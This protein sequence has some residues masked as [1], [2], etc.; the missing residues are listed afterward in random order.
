MAYAAGD[1]RWINAW[2]EC[3]R[4]IGAFLTAARRAGVRARRSIGIDVPVNE[5]VR[6][7]PFTVTRKSIPTTVRVWRQ[8]ATLNAGAAVTNTHNNS[9]SKRLFM[10]RCCSTQGYRCWLCCKASTAEPNAALSTSAA[11]ACKLSRGGCRYLRSAALASRM[12]R[13]SESLL[14]LG[15]WSPL[16]SSLPTR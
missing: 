7:A 9:C 8:Q 12:P 4:C 1:C 15:H 3:V 11:D 13:N 5:A 6:I 14:Q 16:A 10:C 2:I